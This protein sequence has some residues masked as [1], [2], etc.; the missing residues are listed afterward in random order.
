MSKYSRL[1][2]QFTFV[3]AVCSLWTEVY[4][5]WTIKLH[6][7]LNPLRPQLSIHGLH[8]MSFIWFVNF[9]YF[10]KISCPLF[11]GDSII[12]KIV[13]V[14]P[15]KCKQRHN[16]NVKSFLFVCVQF[17][18]LKPSRPANGWPPWIPSSAGVFHMYP[19]FSNN[20]LFFP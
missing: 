14:C 19:H 5:F 10:F 20:V 1:L 7:Q 2:K 11:F 16:Q 15:F 9:K 4:C 3:H 8:K 6:T 17:Y 18:I 12:L 13:Y